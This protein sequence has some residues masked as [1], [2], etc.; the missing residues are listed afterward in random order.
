M[1]ILVFIDNLRAGGK[2]R[3]CVELLKGL[4]TASDTSFEILV[5]NEE[6]YF[7]E[8]FTLNTKI[9]YLIRRT[10]KDISVF[11]KFYKICKEYKPDIVHCWNDMTAV[12]AVPACKLL[13]INLVNGMVSDAPIHQ[14]ILNKEWLCAQLTFPFSNVII[15]NSHAGL[16]AYKAPESKSLVIYNGFDFKRIENLVSSDKI[17]N[18]LKIK[19]KFVIGMVASFSKYKDYSTYFNAAQSV[20]STRNDVTFIAIG[21]NT[22]SMESMSLIDK[23]YQESIKL[24]GKRSNIESYI[25]VMDI[26]VL[27][28]FTEGI[29]NSILEYMALGKPVIATSGGGT[30]EIV[31]HRKTGFLVKKSDKEEL[32]EKI[33]LLLDNFDLRTEMGRNGQERVHQMFSIDSMVSKYMSCYEN[34][35]KKKGIKK[36]LPEIL[37]IASL[38]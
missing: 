38:K 31:D 6:I 24:I 30:N 8:V 3:R 23:R 22:E 14:N 11:A 28:T 1:K 21:N 16:K 29:S 19:T 5:M 13:S 17:R 2:E 34:L 33:N 10:K 37:S 18:E 15:G 35:Q 26:C 25:M 27:A 36:R 32:A 9:H 7:Q 12:I 4:N 20:L